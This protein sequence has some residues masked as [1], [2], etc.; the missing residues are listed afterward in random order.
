MSSSKNERIEICR[1]RRNDSADASLPG[2]EIHMRKYFVAA[3]LLFSLI[4]S[5]NAFSQGGFFGTVTGTVTDSTGALIPGVNIKATATDTGVVTTTLSN[6][7]GAYNFANLLPGKYTFTASLTGLT[8]QNITDAVIGANQLYRYN[9]KMGVSASAT[10]VDVSISAENII[11]TSGATIGQALSE[12][13]VHDLP[14]VGNNVLNLLSTLSG[15]EGLV[16]TNGGFGQNNAFGREGTTLAGVNASNIPTVRDGVIVSDTRY[17][18]GINA[19]TVMNPDLVGEVR[20]IL[21]PVDA[22]LGRGN[23]TIV[24]TTRS[25]TN[26]YTGTAVWTIRNSALN[27]NT[28]ANNTNRTLTPGTPQFQP[29]GT[30]TKPS[31]T[32][33]NWNNTNQATVEFRWSDC[34]K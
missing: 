4:F 22:E 9:F 8:T 25:G 6:E 28:W 7:T 19:A 1:L 15:V 21:A 24:I 33:V 31:A 34:Q 14:L 27:P 13:K 18:T 2:G 17:P 23:G 3:A 16:G 26:K 10:T 5:I 20:L 30:P 32:P 11:A 12:Q 29:D